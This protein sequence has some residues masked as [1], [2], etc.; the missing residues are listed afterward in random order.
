[1][2][3]W[4][5]ATAVV[6]ELTRALV[7]RPPAAAAWLT[8]GVQLGFVVGALGS[9]L[10]NLADVVRLNRLM[11]AS[12]ALAAAANLALLAEP[13]RRRG[14]RRPVRDRRWRWP[15]SIRRR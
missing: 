1:M 13:G 12:A 14:D 6:P 11:A 5:S 7:A 2:T 3:T 10:V 15:G 4:F 8:N 9:S